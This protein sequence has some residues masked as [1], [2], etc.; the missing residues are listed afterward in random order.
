MCFVDTRYIS[1]RDTMEP[2]QIIKSLIVNK[3]EL[4][5]T[6]GVKFTTV[7]DSSEASDT[8]SDV[9]TETDSQVETNGPNSEVE[10]QIEIISEIDL[11]SNSNSS[12]LKTNSSTL[13]NTETLEGTLTEDDVSQDELMT[14]PY[15]L[16]C[17]YNTKIGRALWMVNHDKVKL[18]A[19][20]RLYLVEDEQKNL[21]Q[22]KLL[23]KNSCICVEKGNCAHILAVQHLN[24]IDI[25]N[26][27]KLPNIAKITKAKNSGSTGRKRR[28]HHVNSIETNI[29]AGDNVDDNAV[30]EATC[31]LRMRSILKQLIIEETIL[32][33]VLSKDF[34]IKP[35]MLTKDQS[36]LS[37]VFLTKINLDKVYFTKTAWSMVQKLIESKISHCTCSICSNVCLENCIECDTCLY[38]YHFECASVSSYHRSGKSKN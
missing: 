34:K 29:L 16:K 14:K 35:S 31:D 22:V 17:N 8:N 1:T 28:G 18:D 21:F 30:S 2:T 12:V 6:A 25:S 20:L 23:P 38:W 27:Y 37:D 7:S 13:K 26:Q 4:F 5:R 36:K 33:K 9:D 32:D 10:S 11:I 3:D 24:G 15:E 19:R